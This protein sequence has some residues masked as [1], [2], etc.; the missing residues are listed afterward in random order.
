MTATQ[1]AM[2][3]SIHAPARGATHIVHSIIAYFFLFQSTLPRGERR[4]DA[5]LISNNT[6]NF[7]PRSREGSDVYIAFQDQTLNKFQSTLPR[8]ER[9]LHLHIQNG[10]CTI[11]IHAPARGA[12]FKSETPYTQGVISIHAPARGATHSIFFKISWKFQSTLPRGERRNTT[13]APVCIIWDFNPRS[14]EGSDIV[15]I[16]SYKFAKISIH[17]PAR[18]ATGASSSKCSRIN[19]FNPRSREGS[20]CFTFS[21]VILLFYFN[22]RSREGSDNALLLALL[23]CFSFQSTLPR[24]ERLQ[25]IKT[26]ILILEFQ[27]TLPRGERLILSRRPHRPH[28]FQSTLPRGERPQIH[29]N[30]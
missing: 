8:G 17:A 15:N 13:Q 22:P 26:D 5:V 6:L 28:S 12:T 21:V 3:I 2:L 1:K 19:Y 16:G 9:L 7:N 10:N 18:G 24:G 29:T 20:D 25:I 23:Y 11:S 14:R 27:S 30:N 4:K